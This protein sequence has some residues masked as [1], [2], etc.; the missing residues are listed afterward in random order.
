M[1]IITQYGLHLL[2]FRGRM[3]SSCN[4]FILGSLA[5]EGCR[6]N[7]ITQLC[8]VFCLQP[9]EVGYNYYIHPLIITIM[10]TNVLFHN[11]QSKFT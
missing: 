11:D 7:T 5:S 10:E 9:S 3:V 6:Q 8:I 4:F 2:A 1:N